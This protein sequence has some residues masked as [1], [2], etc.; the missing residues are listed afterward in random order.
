MLAEY[1]RGHDGGDAN[2]DAAALASVQEITS[3]V[4]QL[5]LV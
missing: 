3:T 2:D 5:T 1:T 4:M